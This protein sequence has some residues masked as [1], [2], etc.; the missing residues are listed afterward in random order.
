MQTKKILVAAVLMLAGAAFAQSFPSKPIRLV[1]PNANVGLPDV[2]ARMVAAKMSESIGQPVIVENKPSAGGIIAG[3]MVAKA[4]PDGYTLLLFGNGEYAVAPA[5]YGS[6]LRDH[7][8]PARD[9]TP[10][11]QAI[12]GTYFLVANSSLG[13]NSVS[14]L[15]AL[16]KAK[17]GINYGS[18]GN[19]QIPHLAL[20]QFALM[21]G[22]NL[23]HVPYKGV[24][25]SVPALLAGDVSVT[26]IALPAVL[27]HVKAGK[28]RILAAAS[29]QRSLLMPE[30]PTVGESGLP[31][32]EFEV[33]LGFFAPAGTPRAVI[34]RLNIEMVKALKAPDSE[35]R[36]ATFGLEVMAGTP[37]QFGER[38]R[39]DQEYY[40][41][42]VSQIG[43]KVD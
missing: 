33:S 26:L 5:L 39:K 11:V 16:A 31:G 9:F 27:S 32:Y 8:D 25:Q 7:Y 17:P 30:V 19:G 3:E 2:L 4:A 35:S 15:I 20:A 10:V 42:L 36:L 28:L 14:E 22:V 37:E 34:Q 41:K 29:P 12:R 43:L 24:A 6:K 40:G 13:V 1:L 38:I 21:A 23:T 18:P